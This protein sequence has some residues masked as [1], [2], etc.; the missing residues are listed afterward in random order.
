MDF[1]GQRLVIAICLLCGLL[2]VAVFLEAGRELFLLVKSFACLGFK[3]AQ[4]VKR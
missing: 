3:S 1:S 2:D 4:V